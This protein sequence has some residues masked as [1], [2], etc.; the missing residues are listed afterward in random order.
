M[1]G[2]IHLPSDDSLVP[3]PSLHDKKGQNSNGDAT[4]DCMAWL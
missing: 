4:S 1:C 2:R 3:F